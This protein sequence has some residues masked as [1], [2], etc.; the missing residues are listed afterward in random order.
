MK[1]S[2]TAFGT[3]G[4]SEQ[5]MQSRLL[6]TA[7]VVASLYAAGAPGFG[8]VVHAIFTHSHGPNEY[9]VIRDGTPPNKH[10]SIAAHGHGEH[11]SQGTKRLTPG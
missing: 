8:P 3:V 7:I 4:R 5:L 1:Q 9:V 10:F 11:D 2:R 6:A